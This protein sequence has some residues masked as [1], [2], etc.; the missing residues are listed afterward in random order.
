M[1]EVFLTAVRSLEET[2]NKI[3]YQLSRY[4]WRI[5]EGPPK[6]ILHMNALMN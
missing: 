2:S 1:R 6:E 4:F 3:K 5:R